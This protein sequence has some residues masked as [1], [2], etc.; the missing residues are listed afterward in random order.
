MIKDPFDAEIWAR[1]TA[2]DEYY[3]DERAAELACAFFPRFL[4]HTKGEWA[5]KPFILEPWQKSIVRAIFGWKRKDDGTRRFR[6]VYIIIPRKNGKTQFAAGL[7]L[8]LAFCDG[9]LGAEVY[10][11]ANDRDQA[12][13]CFNEA[14]RM[15]KYAPALS[16]RLLTN[17]FSVFNRKKNQSYKVLSSEFGTKDGLNAS[18]VVYDEFH[19]FRDRM[20]Y[21]VMHTSTGARRQP[22]EIII[23]TAGIDKHSICY[24]L[25][26][27]AINVRDGTGGYVDT[28][29]LPVIY[30][31]DPEDD[32]SDPEVWAKAN[33]NLGKTVKLKYM[34]D[35]AE[36]A[37][38]QPAY[39]N[40]FKRL[41]LNIW[42]EQ[43][44]R[45]LQ[46]AQWDKGSANLTSL[47]EIGALIRAEEETLRGRQCFAG[48]DL[49]RVKDL[50]SLCLVFPP[51]EADE[52]WKF[53][54][55]FWCPKENIA[56]RSLTDRVPYEVWARFGFIT[57][58]PGNTTDFSY[59]EKEISD[60]AGIYDIAEVPY[61]RHFAGEIVN[62]LVNE[63]ITM[64]PFGQGF[65]SMASPTAEFERLVLSENIQHYGHPIARWNAGNVTVQSDPAG[66]IKPDKERSVDR[67]DGIVAAI[68]GLGRAMVRNADKKE[69]AVP[70]MAFVQFHG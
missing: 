43:A 68:M 61:D 48:L 60:L 45:W 9:E 4:T 57:P 34:R 12:G 51:V 28:E 13:L 2:T 46:L 1:S 14:V 23:T 30:C 29:F 11:V 50:S 31:A 27:H 59:I 19:A 21:D 16:E 24:E 66:N 47:A 18:G 7:A 37:K 38:Q 49:A 36:K 42:T 22:L 8:Y 39:E 54:W 32:I 62:N 63:G 35:E 15:V 70:G 56:Q 5:G 53:I 44:T 41:H 6:V 52:K 25:H 10:S 67:I 20:L 55:R 17:K 33:P 3:F 58:T 26:R 64:V 69:V 65:G 40:T